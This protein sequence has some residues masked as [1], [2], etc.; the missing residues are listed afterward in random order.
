M[1]KMLFLALML[2][3]AVGAMAQIQFEE[4]SLK[5]A[6]AKAKAENKLVMVIGSTT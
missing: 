2:F 4:G 3:S 6:L 5:E 1:R